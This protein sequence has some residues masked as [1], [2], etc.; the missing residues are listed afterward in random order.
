[1]SKLSKWFGAAVLVLFSIQV[2][3]T[4]A[5][6]NALKSE[7]E[8]E[9]FT[10][11]V[12]QAVGRGDL[13]AAYTAMKVYSALPPEEVDAGLKATRDQHTPEFIARYGKTIGADYIGKKKLGTTLLRMTY[14]ERGANHPLAWTFYFYLT[15]AGWVL[16]QFGWSDQSASLFL[17][18]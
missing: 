18:D 13:G 7:L 16:S 6:A 2:A 12:M 11:R 5:A 3:P 4:M 8:V 17:L 9:A 15:N 10:G 14:V 1:M